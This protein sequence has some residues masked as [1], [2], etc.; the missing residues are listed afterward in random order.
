MIKII[1]KIIF[2]LLLLGFVIVTYGIISWNIFGGSTFLST[3]GDCMPSMPKMGGPKNVSDK[4]EI[5]FKFFGYRCT[6][7]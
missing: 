3:P 7:W 6:T 5:W 4:P 1:K 2:I